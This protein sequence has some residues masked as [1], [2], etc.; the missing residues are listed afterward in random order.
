LLSFNSPHGAKVVVVVVG[1]AVV[2]V[3]AGKSIIKNINKRLLN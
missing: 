1:G 3:G 2:V